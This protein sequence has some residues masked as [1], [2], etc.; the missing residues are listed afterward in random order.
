V[1]KISAP[2]TGTDGAPDFVNAYR[3]DLVGTTTERGEAFG[4]LMHKEIVKFATYE[5]GK[6]YMKAVLNLDFDQYPEPLQDI[7]RVIQVKG[8]IAAPAAINKALE[9]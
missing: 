2:F 1:G 8:A 3:L 4:A 6:Y 9:W 5:L 7:L